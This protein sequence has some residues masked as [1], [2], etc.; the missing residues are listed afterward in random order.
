M[1]I[2]DI[3]KLSKLVATT[4]ASYG[5]LEG[6]R[7]PVVLK[8]PLTD[9]NGSRFINESGPCGLRANSSKS[10]SIVCQQQEVWHPGA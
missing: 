4:V 9:P 1:A 5:D 3:A 6:A 7:D 10:A 8:N 2:T